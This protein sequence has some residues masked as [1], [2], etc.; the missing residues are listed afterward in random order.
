MDPIPFTIDDLTDNIDQATKDAICE[1][2]LAWARYD[3]L[4]TQLVV[5]AF[6]LSLDTGPVLLGNMETRTK[7]DRLKKLYDHFGMEKAAESI[8]NLRQWHRRYVDIRNTIA[9]SGCGGQ[10]KSDP[11]TI[12]F[13][14]V[15]AAHGE[16]GRM[17]VDQVHIDGIRK[18]TQFAMAAGNNLLTVTDELV[19]RPS[20]QP[21]EPPSFQP[22]PDPNPQTSAGKGN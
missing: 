5:L 19:V 7:L 10:R 1:L 13:A 18:A 15:K 14:P 4:V 21:P 2:I 12:I 3:S 9:H 16:L 22:P 8:G 17:I 11:D 20:A 6:G